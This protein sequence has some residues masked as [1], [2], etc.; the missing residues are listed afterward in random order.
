[1]S[2]EEKEKSAAVEYSEEEFGSLSSE[3]SEG[4]E[5]DWE[6]FKDQAKGMIGNLNAFKDIYEECGGKVQATLRGKLERMVKNEEA[7]KKFDGR[8]PVYKVL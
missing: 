1:M 5:V 2:E 7:E 8:T 6:S 3:K 4:T